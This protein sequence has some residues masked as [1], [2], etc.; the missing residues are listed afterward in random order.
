MPPFRARTW[1]IFGGERQARVDLEA[2]VVLPGHLVSGTLRGLWV[3]EHATS[4]RAVHVGSASHSLHDHVHVRHLVPFRPLFRQVSRRRSRSLGER[5]LDFHRHVRPLAR[6][7][8]LRL[9]LD[10][11]GPVPRQAHLSKTAPAGHAVHVLM[12]WF[13]GPWLPA[14][15]CHERSSSPRW[16][17][18]WSSSSTP[19]WHSRPPSCPSRLV[20]AGTTPPWWPWSSPRAKRRARPPV[21]CQ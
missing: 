19:S 13:G 2:V 4:L 15:W 11:D 14:S 16:S 18:S 1:S 20:W 7:P 3:G 21:V 12:P 6:D 10:I 8:E 17:S 9:A 5:N